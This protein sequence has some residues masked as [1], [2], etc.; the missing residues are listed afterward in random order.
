MNTNKGKG[1]GKGKGFIAIYNPGTLHARAEVHYNE[2]YS[3]PATDFDA[4]FEVLSLDLECNIQIF[5][6]E[7]GEHIMLHAG[8]PL[9]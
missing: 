9:I 1:K 5:D 4:H 8:A 6:L 7:T 2:D 3:D